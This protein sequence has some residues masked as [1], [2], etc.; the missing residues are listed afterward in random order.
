MKALLGKLIMPLSAL[1]ASIFCL[2]SLSI[3]LPLNIAHAA[4]CSNPPDPANL[5]VLYSA[6]GSTPIF[7]AIPATTGDAASQIELSYSLLKKGEKKYGDWVQ[8]INWT[9]VDNSI[10]SNGFQ[11]TFFP[12][13]YSD[14]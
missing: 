2:F 12:I 1:I 10:I 8:V 7:T 9:D 4:P 5:K 6:S 11:V 3:L 14:V 13:T